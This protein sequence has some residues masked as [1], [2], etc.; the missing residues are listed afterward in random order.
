VKAAQRG[1]LLNPDRWIPGKAEAMRVISERYQTWRA[2]WVTRL[3]RSSRGNISIGG[4]AGVQTYRGRVDALCADLTKLSPAA[5]KEWDEWEAKNWEGWTPQPPNGEPLVQATPA[6]SADADLLS[7]HT[8]IAQPLLNEYEYLEDLPQEIEKRYANAAP[9]MNADSLDLLRRAELT[10]AEAQLNR[11]SRELAVLAAQTGAERRRW[12]SKG[13][14][15][16]VI[17]NSTGGTGR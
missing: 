6:G 17:E 7:R 3:L 2:R 16:Y 11:V 4:A 13:W 10:A 14:D 5:K 8:S 12:Q 9:A 15:G 1:F